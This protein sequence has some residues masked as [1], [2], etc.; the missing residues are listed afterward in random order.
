MILCIRVCF[1]LFTIH[2]PL[3][4]TSTSVSSYPH[5]GYD[6]SAVSRPYHIN[7]VI[8]YNITRLFYRI[9]II[10]CIYTRAVIIHNTAVVVCGETALKG[11][12][13]NISN[14]YGMINV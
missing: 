4:K 1:L 13:G 2:T 12:V 9:K 14:V 10:L 3:Q 5:C 7:T 11:I 8:I 6:F